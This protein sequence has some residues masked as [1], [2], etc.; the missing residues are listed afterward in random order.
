MRGLRQILQSPD[1]PFAVGVRK[2]VV[3]GLRFVLELA[4]LI[5]YIK[6]IRMHHL[7]KLCLVST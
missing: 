3:R 4:K 5:Q 7:L 1:I 2:H 6:S